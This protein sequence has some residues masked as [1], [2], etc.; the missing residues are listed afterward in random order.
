MAKC[1]HCVKRTRFVRRAAAGAAGCGGMRRDA[2]GFAA[3]YVVGVGRG[4]VVLG[5]GLGNLCAT[6]RTRGNDC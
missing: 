1:A 5:R 4:L 3:T 6:T 2:A